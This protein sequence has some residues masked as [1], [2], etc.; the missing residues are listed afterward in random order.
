LRVFGWRLKEVTPVFR[1]R[2]KATI[3]RQSDPTIRYGGLR[4]SLFRLP[5][6]IIG[7]K[8]K[9]HGA[10]IVSTPERKAIIKSEIDI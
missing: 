7:N 6:I 4:F 5:P 3:D 9:T 10:R 8:G 2:V 1:T